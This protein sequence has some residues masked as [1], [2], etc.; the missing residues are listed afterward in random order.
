VFL[1]F[2]LEEITGNLTLFVPNIPIWP[3]SRQCYHQANE[4]PGICQSQG[5]SSF[6]I[7]MHDTASI[8]LSVDYHRS[9]TGHWE[10]SVQ[11][12]FKFNINKEELL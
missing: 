8:S 1:L 9:R 12:S 6:F 5:T 7:P 4:R 2:Q 10:L 3:L 11:K